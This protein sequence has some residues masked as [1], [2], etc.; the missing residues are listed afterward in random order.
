MPRAVWKGPFIV[1]FKT[2]QEVIRTQARASVVLP[3]HVGQKFEVH[4]GKLFVP[5]T[6]S[7][8]MVGHKLGEFAITRKAGTS[9]K[10]TKKG[11]GK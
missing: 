2:G 7:E 8:H 6:I 11:K 10:D 1:P 5:V 4:N 9:K 3:S